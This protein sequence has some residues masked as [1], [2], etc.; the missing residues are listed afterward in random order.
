MFG[1]QVSGEPV[2]QIAPRPKAV[3]ACHPVFGHPRHRP[4]KTVA[5]QVCKGWQQGVNAGVM[6]VRR[7][8]WRDISD[9][10]V[11]MRH[12]HIGRPSG[13]KFGLL[14]KNHLE[15]LVFMYRHKAH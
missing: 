2:H 8:V 9:A 1:R 6:R 13:R 5:V 11:R 3:F 10:S 15:I 7:L 14:C 4:L 12:T